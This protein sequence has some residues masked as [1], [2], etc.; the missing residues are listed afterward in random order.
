MRFSNK[1]PE[2]VASTQAANIM[3]SLQGERLQAVGTVRNYE[4][5]LRNVALYTKSNF[6]IGLKE[7]SLDVANAYLEVRSLEVK[8]ST[9]DMERQA[10]QVMMHEVTKAI[11][12]EQKVGVVVGEKGHHHVIKSQL[13]TILSTRSYTAQQAHV[14]AHAQTEKHSLSTQLAYASGLRAHELYTLRPN[15]E[16]HADDRPANED[17]FAGRTGQLY[18]VT[19]KGG[20]TREVLIPNELAKQ[21]ENSR[22]TEPKDVVDRGINYTQHYNI[23]AGKNWSNSF[24]S[25][26][27]RTLNWS[28]GA[29]GLRH[30]YAQE[31]MKELRFEMPYEK[32]LEVVSQEMGHF[33]P[34]ITE[35][36]LR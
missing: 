4:Q 8:Q 14:I 30:S 5:A 1:S 24:S 21:L 22:L 2:Q 13:D 6:D 17:K 29:H 12:L 9:L 18:T 36:Y 19:G 27:N 25:A 32:A 31:R 23:G 3:K 33:R 28:N 20:L 34:D 26:S 10:I 16:V 35:V 7:L 15:S 11:S